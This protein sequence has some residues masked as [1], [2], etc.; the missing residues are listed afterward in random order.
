[1]TYQLR[2]FNS[3]HCITDF[4]EKKPDQSPRRSL[5]KTFNETPKETIPHTY[6]DFFCTNEMYNMRDIS[7]IFLLSF[8]CLSNTK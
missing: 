5:D 7:V 6:N 1:M 2:F 4:P 8:F 3:Y